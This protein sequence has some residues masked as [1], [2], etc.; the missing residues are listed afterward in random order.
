SGK[1]CYQQFRHQEREGHSVDRIEPEE[2]AEG[3]Q[4]DDPYHRRGDDPHGKRRTIRLDALPYAFRV[5][6]AWKGVHGD[7]YAEPD[8]EPAQD[9][10]GFELKSRDRARQGD[11]STEDRV[12]KERADADPD[13]L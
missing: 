12:Q 9:G 5:T 3:A 11:Q 2:R 13:M 4:I 6:G 8:E 10:S 1:Q 7:R